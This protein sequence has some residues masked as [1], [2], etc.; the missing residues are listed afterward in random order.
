MLCD[1]ISFLGDSRA[2]SEDASINLAEATI[3][4]RHGGQVLDT[5]SRDWQ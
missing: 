5:V 1:T 4:L 2:R 3:T